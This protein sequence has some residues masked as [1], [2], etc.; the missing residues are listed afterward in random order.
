MLATKVEVGD[1]VND[2]SRHS[3]RLLPSGP[4]RVG[5]RPVRLRAP[6]PLYQLPQI[7]WQPS[8]RR[9][10]SSRA[11]SIS[12]KLDRRQGKAGAIL[13]GRLREETSHARFH[14]AAA[15]PRRSAAGFL[16]GTDLGRNP[17]LYELE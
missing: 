14:S 13:P 11:M 8:Q 1:R 2:P 10:V 6:A 5:E 4:D 16:A 17:G 7:A 12:E 9:S 3:L 15:Q